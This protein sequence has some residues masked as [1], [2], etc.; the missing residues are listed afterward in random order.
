[1][2]IYFILHPKKPNVIFFVEYKYAAYLLN[3]HRQLT[4]H[5][6]VFGANFC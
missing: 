5:E 6:N 3:Q 4:N 1:M 2:Y